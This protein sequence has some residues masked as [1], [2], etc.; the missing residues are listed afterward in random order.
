MNRSLKRHPPE[1]S[2]VCGYITNAVTHEPVEN[3]RVSTEWNLTY[4]DSSGFYL[5]NVAAG[6][7]SIFVEKNGYS[8]DRTYRRDVRENKTVWINL[9]LFPE[10]IKTR[11]DKPLKALYVNNR[12]VMPSSTPVVIGKIDVEVSAS[13]YWNGIDKIEFYVDND[14]QATITSWPY[15]WI[16]DSTAFGK[17]T[18]RVVA[19]ND[20]GNTASDELTLWKFF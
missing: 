18:L 14:L 17:K 11:I 1:T 5:C 15:R 9:S 19:Y 4:C 12:I 2:M 16:W 20:L 7:I 8:R 10:Q 6:E 3:A 13:D